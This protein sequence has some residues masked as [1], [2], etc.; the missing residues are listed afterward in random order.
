MCIYTLR[1]LYDLKSTNW[2]CLGMYN[3]YMYIEIKGKQNNTKTIMI[4]QAL[5]L[6]WTSWEIN[7][8]EYTS[9][10]IGHRILFNNFKKEKVKTVTD[11]TPD[12]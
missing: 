7:V 4:K 8:H 6:R 1:V 2:I 12:M 10:I 5:I 3:L 11:R 9:T